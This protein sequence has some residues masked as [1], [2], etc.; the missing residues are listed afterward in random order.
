MKPPFVWTDL[1]KSDI[2]NN[3]RY[4]NEKWG[5][6]TSFNF[7][8]RLMESLEVVSRNPTTFQIINK[9]LSIRRFI[10][11]NRITLYYQVRKHDILL[12]TFFGTTAKTL[13]N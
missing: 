1:A 7:L 13:K 11:N 3:L 2:G 5:A 10:V 8:R 12:I 6:Q 9:K 4:V